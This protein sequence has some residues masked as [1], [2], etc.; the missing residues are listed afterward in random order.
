MY[1][2]NKY[3]DAT[4]VNRFEGFI[5]RNGYFYKV[6]KRGEKITDEKGR[7]RDSHNLWA[8]AFL[9]EKMNITEFKF[10]PTASALFT[11][12]KLNG[13]AEILIHCFGYI[14]YSHDP[15]YFK[16]IIKAP[17]QKIANYKATEEQLNTLYSI[18]FLNKEDTN[19]SIF[20]CEEE[21]YD[22]YGEYEQN[23]IKILKK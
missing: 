7:I 21:S 23:K 13:P 12:T 8:E 17:N 9:K 2:F 22:Y 18:M 6:A 11:L 20:F 16:P 15:I 5:D 10:N 4:Q 3:D 1:D 14:Y 19:I